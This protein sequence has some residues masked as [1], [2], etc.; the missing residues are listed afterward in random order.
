MSSIKQRTSLAF[1]FTL[2][3][4][5]IIVSIIT[6]FSIENYLYPYFDE[7]LLNSG[8][9]I[10]KTLLIIFITVVANSFLFNFLYRA[11][12]KFEDAM[13]ELEKLDL[14]RG[15]FDIKCLTKVIN[16]E[17][18]LVKLAR[19]GIQENFFLNILLKNASDGFMV[20]DDKGRILLFSRSVYKIFKIK[21]QDLTGDK[22]DNLFQFDFFR[23]GHNKQKK[24]N[25]KYD[26]LTEKFLITVFS[27]ENYDGI[28]LEVKENQTVFENKKIFCYLIKDITESYARKDFILLSERA[29]KK[30]LISL[31]ASVSMLVAENNLP[32][33]IKDVVQIASKNTLKLNNLIEDLRDIL[34][35]R[36][37]LV[38]FNLVNCN[39]AGIISDVIEA[40]IFYAQEKNIKITSYCKTDVSMVLTD[41]AWL[42][43]A[44]SKILINAINCTPA[45]EEIFV[46]QEYVNQKIRVSVSD[47]GSGIPKKYFNSIMK[48]PLDNTNKYSGIAGTGVELI[49]ARLIVDK[50]G[51]FMGFDTLIDKGTTFYFELPVVDN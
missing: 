5:I 10:V 25:I 41:P 24:K 18:T 47:K 6:S 15:N 32:E 40:N 20:T 39:I 30:P 38:H 37:S 28:I 49:L 3:T 21:K 1:F 43:Q 35:L 26:D 44:F 17:S 14:A 33:N 22:I 16:P 2:T 34:T 31:R 8:I 50:L 23:T 46:N 12:K 13:Q 45:C 4:T 19:K 7:K 36:L 9:I 27:E 48:Q 11:E 42:E 29:I 51:G